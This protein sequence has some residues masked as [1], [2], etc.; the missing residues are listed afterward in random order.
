M[1]KILILLMAVMV[2]MAAGA[3]SSGSGGNNASEDEEAPDFSVELTDGSTFT[4]SEH[5]DDVVMLNFWATWCSYCVDEMP[6]IQK[7][8]DDNI[9]GLSIVLVDCAETKQDV[10]DFLKETGYTFDVAYDEEDSVSQ[11]Y[12]AFTIPRTVIIKDGKIKKIFSGA[13]VDPYNEYKSAV[14]EYLK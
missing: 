2:L 14:E 5:K 9:D 3:C 12:G 11:Q 8:T 13:P 4:L 6:D 1:K 10:D 7:L